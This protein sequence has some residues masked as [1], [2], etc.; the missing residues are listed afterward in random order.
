MHVFMSAQCLVDW[1]NKTIGDS[2]MFCCDPNLGFEKTQYYPYEGVA[3]TLLTWSRCQFEWV[4]RYNIDRFNHAYTKE[5]IK[6]AVVK[7]YYGR[8]FPCI[9]ILNSLA[10]KRPRPD[11]DVC[12]G[13]NA[14]LIV[15]LDITM[16]RSIAVTSRTLGGR[17]GAKRGSLI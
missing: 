3:R 11:D 1:G 5:G 4:V 2:K 12:Q 14:N 17:L 9:A 15:V 13:N 16:K 10:L 8:G 7:K 6:H